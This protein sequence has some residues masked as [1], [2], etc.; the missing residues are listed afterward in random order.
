MQGKMQSYYLHSVA[1]D[2]RKALANARRLNLT[3]RAFQT[4]A[5]VRAVH[6][7]ASGLLE[8]ETTMSSRE[9]KGRGG[10]LAMGRLTRGAFGAESGDPRRRAAVV[11]RRSRGVVSFAFAPFS[12]FAAFTVT[13]FA[14][15]FPSF[16][17]LSDAV[18]AAARRPLAPALT[19]S[20]RSYTHRAGASRGT[21]PCSGAPVRVRVSGRTRV[22][23]VYIVRTSPGQVGLRNV[24]AFLG[25]IFS[26]I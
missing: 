16:H 1:K 9:G 3:V 22:H 13:V 5:Y 2:S 21:P 8:C 17:C 23:L 4:K 18:C 25:P 24:L 10:R 12:P 26:S 20:I 7:D 6:A 14:I 11:R 15:S 19:I